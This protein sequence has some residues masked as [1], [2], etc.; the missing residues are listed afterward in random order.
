MLQQWNETSHDAGRSLQGKHRPAIASRRAIPEQRR[1]AAV[2]PNIENIRHALVI[3]AVFRAQKIFGVF[4]EPRVGTFLAHRIDNAGV[5]VGVAQN[6]QFRCTIRLAARPMRVGATP[7][8]RG[9]FHHGVNLFRPVLYHVHRQSRRACRE[10]VFS[11][12]MNHCGVLR[13]SGA[14][15]ASSIATQF[16]GKGARGL[17][18][19]RLQRLADRLCLCRQRARRNTAH[20]HNRHPLHHV[21]GNKPVFRPVQNVRPCRQYEPDRCRFH[22]SQNTGQQ[23]HIKIIALFG[24]WVFAGQR[25]GSIS[26]GARSFNICGLIT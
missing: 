1:H 20:H 12:E 6:R 8:S 10:L 23:W 9:G 21:K 4:I 5:H 18:Q 22:Q 25:A 2:K 15:N 14:L 13:K 3:I 16:P 26:S 19:P 17:H 11:I 24:Q 7:P